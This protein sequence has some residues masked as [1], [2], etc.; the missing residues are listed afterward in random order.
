M[1]KSTIDSS[2]TWES[3]QQFANGKSSTQLANSPKVEEKF[4]GKLVEWSGTVL[5][6]DSFDEDMEYVKKM[7]DSQ[8][9]TDMLSFEQLDPYE[10]DQF[11]M[12]G[13]YAAQILV[14]MSP[15]YMLS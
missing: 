7:S 4:M 9:G 13:L 2:I 3:F 10:K 5:R 12:T 15:R 8:N 11:Q 6:V 1:E 14:R